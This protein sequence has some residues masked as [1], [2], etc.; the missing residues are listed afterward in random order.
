MCTCVEQDYENVY[1]VFCM[2]CSA[3]VY[4]RPSEVEAW[5]AWDRRDDAAVKKLVEVA[6]VVADCMESTCCTDCPSFVRC[7]DQEANVKILRQIIK[8]VERL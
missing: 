8:E 1:Y 6:K 3:E 2:S 4:Y 5:E 7:E